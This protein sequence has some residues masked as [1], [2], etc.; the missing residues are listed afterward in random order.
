[1]VEWWSDASACL[2]ACAASVDE[3]GA[4][5]AGFSCQSELLRSYKPSG[6]VWLDL[7]GGARRVVLSATYFG[8]A[9]KPN[10]AMTA[11]EASPLVA[12]ADASSETRRT[13]AV[14]LTMGAAYAASCAKVFVDRALDSTEAQVAEVT[15]NP[16]VISTLPGA[17]TGVYS[18]GKVLAMLFIYLIGGKLPLVASATA[19]VASTLLFTIGTA[20]AFFLSWLPF[21]LVSSCVPLLHPF[22]IFPSFRL[23]VP[24]SPPHTDGSGPLRCSSLSPG[25]TPP[26][27]G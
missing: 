26:I 15:S 18:V 20:A 8:A 9:P 27:T 19:G 1:M 4:R 3:A 23:T 17:G 12:S 6:L 10:A 21:R 25:W 14:I 22:F 7:R 13:R 2:G 5:P 16:L 11:T 24:R